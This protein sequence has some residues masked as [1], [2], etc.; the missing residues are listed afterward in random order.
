MYKNVK[1][2]PLKILKKHLKAV[3]EGFRVRKIMKFLEN[4][5]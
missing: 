3:I 1:K 5:S 4:N 2:R